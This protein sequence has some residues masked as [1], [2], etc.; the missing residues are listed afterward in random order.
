MIEDLVPFSSSSGNRAFIVIRR[1]NGRIA[2]S[3]GWERKPSNLDVDECNRAMAK[4]FEVPEVISARIE[5]QDKREEL[6]DLLTRRPQH[7]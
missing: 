5:D 1:A 2:C 6:I 3:C 4:Y 7:G